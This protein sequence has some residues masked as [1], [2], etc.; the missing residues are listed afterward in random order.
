M[1]TEIVQIMF[2]VP[3]ELL[4]RLR[5]R[6]AREQ[7]SVSGILCNAAEV[8]LATRAHRGPGASRGDESAEFLANQ[9]TSARGLTSVL[10]VGAGGIE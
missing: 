9:K 3:E 1:G 8:Y 7:T 6:A 4:H 2:H 10:S 5:V